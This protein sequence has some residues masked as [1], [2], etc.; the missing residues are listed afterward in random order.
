MFEKMVARYI[1][2]KNNKIIHLFTINTVKGI[3]HTF[4][5]HTETLG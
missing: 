3:K 4:I 1:I 2:E 5:K